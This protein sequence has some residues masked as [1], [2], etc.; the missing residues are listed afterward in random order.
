MKV[1]ITYTGGLNPQLDKKVIKFF[2]NLD[3]EWTGSGMETQTQIRDITFIKTG[4][5]TAVDPK[6]PSKGNKFVSTN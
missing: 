3:Y 1:K 5:V 2:E 6:D 4:Y